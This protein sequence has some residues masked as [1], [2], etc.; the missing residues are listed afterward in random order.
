[1]CGIVA[2]FSRRDPISAALMDRATQSIYHRGATPEEVA[3]EGY[4][5]TTTNNGTSVLIRGQQ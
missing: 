2:V 1:M 3:R 4:K 5:F